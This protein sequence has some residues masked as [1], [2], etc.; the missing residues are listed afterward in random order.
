MKYQSKSTISYML[1]NFWRL[2]PWTLAASVLAGLFMTDQPIMAFIRN[3]AD[4]A[5]T[6]DTFFDQLVR[7]VT[8]LRFGGYWWCALLTVLLLVL[9]ESLLIVKVSRH[10]RVGEMLRFPLKGALSVLPTAL[11]FALGITVV[12]EALNLAVVGIAYLVRSASL[13]AAMVV[14]AVLLFAVRALTVFGAA[15]LLLSF[16]IMFEENYRFSA[17]L[18]YSV[19][20]ALDKPG[21]LIFLSLIYPTIQLALTALCAWANLPALTVVLYSVLYF[22]FTLYA[23]CAAFKIYYDSVGCV[24]RDITHSIF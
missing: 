17:A 3:Y 5:V 1:R 23:P 20:L 18:S 6:A 21:F 4:G 8:V 22:F 16:P 13:I 9:V 11:L 10:M 14:S 2:A 19:R 15:A 7:A 12:C 24:R